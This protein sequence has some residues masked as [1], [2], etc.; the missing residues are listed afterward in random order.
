[1]EGGG[2]KDSKR[3]RLNANTRASSHTSQEYF[4][5]SFENLSL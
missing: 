5:F 2:G 3:A 1:M 4:S